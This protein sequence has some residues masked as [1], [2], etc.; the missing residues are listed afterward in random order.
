MPEKPSPTSNR[1]YRENYMKLRNTCLPDKFILFVIAFISA[2]P[3]LSTDLYVP[4]LPQMAEILQTT[5]AKINLTL[6]LFFVFF[7]TGILIWGP[8]SDKY[9]RKPILYCGLVIY[10]ISSFCCAWAGSYVQL[11]ISRVFQAFGG[12]AAT[13]VATAIVKDMYTG[14]KRANV[15]AV[16]MALVIT[17]PVVAPILGSLL[18]KITSWRAIF[19]ALALF[20]VIALLIAVPLEETLESRFEG[21]AIHSMGRLFVV[22]RNPGFS[23]LLI[24]FSTV[25]MPL[26]AFIA[27]A[28]YVYIKGFGLSE[29]TFSLFFSANAVCAMMG[30]ILYIRI[31]KR[32]HYNT[33]IST[34]FIVLSISGLM[35]CMLGNFSPYMFAFT[36]M[37]ATLSITTMRPP[38]ANLMLEQQQQDTGSA[39]SLINFL[40]MIMGSVGMMLISMRT[41]HFIFSI[42]IMEMTVGALGFLSWMSVKNRAFIAQV[43]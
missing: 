1:H 24:I 13:A 5:P 43:R 21:S 36:M 33:I 39:S 35:V 17:A 20:G 15:L 29:Q 40:G 8:L 2:F 6:S 19:L 9:G 14:E 3:P 30:P 22:M 31:S 41:D 38:S 27:A 26:M 34:C 12:G 7:G 16:V 10:I 18:L 23:W 42:G 32:L 28:S 11:V 4:A 37:P 25:A